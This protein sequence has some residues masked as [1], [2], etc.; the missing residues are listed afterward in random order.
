MP[1]THQRA[2]WLLLAIVALALEAAA[3][4]FQ[5]GMELDP[6]VLC[7]YQRAAVLGLLL[8]ALIGLS[9]PRQLVARTLGYLGWAAS[10]T[11]CL[12]L[13]LKLSGIQ[14]GFI[15]PSM[16]CD[17]NAKFPVWLKLDRWLPSLFQPTGFCGDIQWQFLGLSMPQWMAIVMSALLLAWIAALVSEVRAWLCSRRHASS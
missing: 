17:V 10:A 9:A 15:A 14:L 7:V 2:P 1:I 12:Y 13:A 11:W 6:C 5:Y 8:S 3:L 16:S 4:Y